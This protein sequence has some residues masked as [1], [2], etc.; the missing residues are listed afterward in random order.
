[1]ELCVVWCCLVVWW[2][3]PQPIVVVVNATAMW[4]A[5]RLLTVAVATVG[6][7]GSGWLCRALN[8]VNRRCIEGVMAVDVLI[9]VVVG[10]AT[11]TAMW[12]AEGLL[13][14]AVANAGA[15]GSGNV[16]CGVGRALDGVNRRC[17]D[18]VM[19]VDVR[20]GGVVG[21]ATATAMW[22]AEGLLAV[23]VAAVGKCGSGWV[24]VEL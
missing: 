18:G 23:A 22:C 10:F 9:C 19:A 15:C 5:E 6:K 11:A 24:A 3:L 20:V 8:G 17:I 13:A 21:F 16:Q 4:C 1:M 7:C 2:V 12:C 14:V